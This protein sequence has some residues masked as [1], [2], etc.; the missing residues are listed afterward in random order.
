MD[1]ADRKGFIVRILRQDSGTAAGVGFVVADR[2]LI[3]CAHVVNVALGRKPRA[4][5]QPPKNVRLRVDFPLLSQD[6]DAPV[7]S[8]QVEAWLAPAPLT[9][10]VGG[11]D[12]AGLLVMGEALPSG[13][14]PARMLD[15]EPKRD[16]M[17][18]VFGYPS[19][20][21]RPNGAWVSQRLRGAVG[22][23]IIQLDADSESALRA[24]PGYSGSP[25]LV[26]D[27]DRDAVAGMLA[28][29]GGRDDDRDAYAMPVA[30][31]AAAWPDVLAPR[32][33][34]GGGS[35]RAGDGGAAQTQP[36]PPV[37]G[38]RD[39]AHTFEP[40]PQAQAQPQAQPPA[41]PQP[42]PQTSPAPAVQTP[43]LAQV[44][45]GNWIVDIRMAQFA[46]TMVLSLAVNPAGQLMFEGFFPGTGERVQGYWAVMGSQVRLS[47]MRMTSMPFPQQGPYDV[48]VSF[49]SWSYPALVGVSSTGESVVWRRQA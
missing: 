7:R 5:D 36:R 38:P 26:K 24:Q 19:N 32:T 29:V 43:T 45:A 13:A 12:V 21:S 39:F 18:D 17:A 22:G 28:V 30:Q 20:A 46:M 4:Q 37:R 15:G 1:F 47:G 2:H 27:Q 40:R 49:G 25:V 11:G 33:L 42:M 10:G 6:Q 23:G 34:A 41:Q 16:V 48:T 44:I 9:G 14:G 35:M 3:T 8:C 31:I